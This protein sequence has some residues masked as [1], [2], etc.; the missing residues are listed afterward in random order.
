MQTLWDVAFGLAAGV[1]GWAAAEFFVK[2]FR[3][4]LDLVTAVRVEMI[5]YGNLRLPFKENRDEP[6][7]PIPTQGFSDEDE[8]RLETAQMV[9]RDL[10]AQ[11]L[12][13]AETE[14]IAHHV[15]KWLRRDLGAAASGLIG[16]SNTDAKGS[17]YHWQKETVEKAIWF[18]VSSDKV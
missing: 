1:V 9:F 11:A 18:N 3:R 16:L 14:F 10:G 6:M 7:E 5:R 8:K 2:P 15:L 12:A 13:F 17:T 4:G